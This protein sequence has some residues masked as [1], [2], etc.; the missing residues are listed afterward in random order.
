M[1]PYQACGTARQLVAAA[2]ANGVTAD[3]P[4][5]ARRRLSPRQ[6]LRRRV[7]S[8]TTTWRRKS[9]LPGSQGGHWRGRRSDP[10]PERWP[11]APQ[12]VGP[13]ARPPQRAH[14]RGRA[15]SPPTSLAARQPLAFLRAQCP[16][17]TGRHPMK[18]GEMAVR[19]H[20]GAL[21]QSRPEEF[22][23]GTWC[24]W[25]AMEPIFS[26]PKDEN[27]VRELQNFFRAGLEKRPF[28]AALWPHARRPHALMLSCEY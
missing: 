28:G 1:P 12:P 27:Q 17:P 9:G 10:I 23:H 5:K 13:R 26:A 8:T 11:R 24:I 15:R 3:D 21:L 4:Q 14:R 18:N 7:G 16:R 6:A 25:C 20:F 19:A 2:L 22:D